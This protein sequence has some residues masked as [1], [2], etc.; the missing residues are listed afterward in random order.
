MR[1][2]EYCILSV[3]LISTSINYFELLPGHEWKVAFIGVA[4]CLFIYALNRLSWNNWP[5]VAVFVIFGMEL[6]GVS[7]GY[8]LSTR[9][10]PFIIIT[11]ALLGLGIPLYLKIRKRIGKK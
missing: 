1:Q 7:L 6:L 9:Q 2:I 3:V 8:N 11:V 4:L 10:F 5:T